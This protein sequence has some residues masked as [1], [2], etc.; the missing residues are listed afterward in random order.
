MEAP[1]S[2]RELDFHF[3]E[4]NKKLV[5]ILAQTTKTNG[6]VTTLEQKVTVL[7]E[8]NKNDRRTV[9][10]IWAIAVVILIPLLVYINHLQ[11]VVVGQMR[12][13]VNNVG[14]NQTSNFNKSIWIV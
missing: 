10:I 6:R 9:M 2:K 8:E 14:Q 12:G 3:G 7:K 13:Q 5:E 4:V 1:Y 11:M